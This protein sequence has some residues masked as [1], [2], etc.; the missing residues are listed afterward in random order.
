MFLPVLKVIEGPFSSLSF[1]TV[2]RVQLPQFEQ[3]VL[4]AIERYL[5]SFDILCDKCYTHWP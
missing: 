1:G 2:E 5:K 4:P 3:S